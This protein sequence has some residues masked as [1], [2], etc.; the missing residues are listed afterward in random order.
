MSKLRQ[1][2]FSQLTASF[3]Q[4]FFILFA[5]TSIIY[6]IRIASLTSIIEVSFLELITLYLYSVPSILLYTLPIVFFVALS[7]TI[8]NLSNEYETIVI[9]SFGLSPYKILKIFLPI[10]LLLVVTLL[11]VALGLIPKTKDLSKVFIENKKSEAK[12][13][14]K[15]S[16]N[17]QKFGDWLVY[18][19]SEKDDVFHGITMFKKESSSKELISSNQAKSEIENGAFLFRLF[20]G[21]AFIIKDEIEQ[22][23]YKR[24]TILNTNPRNIVEQ[25]FSNIKAYWANSNKDQK[26]LRDLA[27]Y[28]LISLFPLISLFWII[29]IGYY[30]PRYEKKQVSL[31][32]GVVVTLYIVL[33]I[34]LNKYIPIESIF[35]ISAIWSIAGFILMKKFVLNRY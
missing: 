31:Y 7:L 19:D 32:T 29:F 5:I 13:N 4:I 34:S 18:I 35:I 22:I 6:L 15:A 2:L 11:I 10:T 33:M 12:L 20:D 26:L 1:Y 17:G 3:F 28:I 23:D 21:R 25:N 27:L 24:L 16:E 9:T 30:N 8:S 14:I